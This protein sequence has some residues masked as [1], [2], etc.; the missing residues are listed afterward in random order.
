[1]I[2]NGQR[3]RITYKEGEH[4]RTVCFIY[5]CKIIDDTKLLFVTLNDYFTM[6]AFSPDEILDIELLSNQSYIEDV[7]SSGIL[8]E[9]SIEK[10]RYWYLNKDK[11]P[12]SPRDLYY[13]ENKVAFKHFTFEE[14]KEYFVTGSEKGKVLAFILKFGLSS[15]HLDSLMGYD[16]S[17]A[18]CI[19]ALKPRTEKELSK[20]IDFVNLNLKKDKREKGLSAQ[21]SAY[22]Y[23]LSYAIKEGANYNDYPKSKV[24]PALMKHMW[25]SSHSKDKL[26]AL[27][28]KLL[29]SD[30]DSNTIYVLVKEYEWILSNLT[31]KQLTLIIEK[32]LLDSES[33]LEVLRKVKHYN[34]LSFR[35]TYNGEFTLD[36]INKHIEMLKERMNPK[37]VIK[38]KVDASMFS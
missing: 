27:Y 19:K 30:L 22:F 1:M 18:W 36:C 9:G 15:D 10:F 26:V 8:D 17:I 28:S 11:F 38:K 3:V 37:E 20:F 13:S 16:E 29:R 25:G 34:K 2:E 35:N 24:K 31:D 7:E 4:T 12:F 21:D 14:F 23:R 32:A 33:I 5:I 6:E